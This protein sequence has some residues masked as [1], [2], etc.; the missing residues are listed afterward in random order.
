MNTISIWFS[1]TYIPSWTALKLSSQWLWKTIG[2]LFIICRMSHSSSLELFFLIKLRFCVTCVTFYTVLY[3]WLTLHSQVCKL[4]EINL[5][6]SG[7]SESISSHVISESTPLIPPVTEIS[8]LTFSIHYSQ[9]I[10]LSTSVFPPIFY[11]QMEEI[12]FLMQIKPWKKKASL[13][14][15]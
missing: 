3:K 12:V 9:K 11:V 13:R 2:F 7:L 5:C 6:L 8:I 15:D 1:P 4:W 14:D 10:S